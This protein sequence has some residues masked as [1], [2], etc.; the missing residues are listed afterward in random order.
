MG[1]LPGKKLGYRLFYLS[2]IFSIVF[3]Y[4]NKL[5]CYYFIHTFINNILYTSILIGEKGKHIEPT[6]ITIEPSKYNKCVR[7]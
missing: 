2:S 7:T 3:Q 4:N 6:Y 5:T 1:V